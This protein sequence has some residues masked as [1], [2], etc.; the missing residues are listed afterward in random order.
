[1]SKPLLHEEALELL[2]WFVNGTLQG[3]EHAAVEQHVRSCVPCRV[4]LQEQYHLRTMIRQQPTVRLSP[5]KDFA[6][7][8]LQVDRSRHFGLRGL[9]GGWNRAVAGWL[10]PSPRRAVTVGVLVA[11]FGL[12]AWLLSSRQPPL[13]PAAYSTSSDTAESTAA[14]VDV[15]FVDGVTESEMRALVREIG[16]TIVAGPS[17]IGRYTI[18]LDAPAVDDDAYRALLGRLQRDRR[19]RF[20]G[21]A[22][23]ADDAP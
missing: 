11:S 8:M 4:A 3:N 23:P 13:E 18:E 9:L 17:D 12:A 19:V 21:R 20:A 2:P 15:V 1:M 10:V 7:L 5:D 16:G 6:D 14:L 22:F